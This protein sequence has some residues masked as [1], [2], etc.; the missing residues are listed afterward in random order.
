MGT[1]E[2]QKNNYVQVI[3]ELSLIGSGVSGMKDRKLKRHALSRPTPEQP[4]TLW[5]IGDLSVIG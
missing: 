4:Y 1:P 3:G 2:I 5:V